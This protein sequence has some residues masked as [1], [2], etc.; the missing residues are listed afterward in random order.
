MARNWMAHK[1]CVTKSLCGT[2]SEF[3]RHLFLQ[4][5][6]QRTSLRIAFGQ[7]SHLFYFRLT[8]IIM[9]TLFLPIWLLLFLCVSKLAFILDDDQTKN[10]KKM[11]DEK[12]KKK[13]KERHYLTCNIN[14]DHHCRLNIKTMNDMR[15][16]VP[17]RNIHIKYIQTSTKCRNK[18]YWPIDCVSFSLDDRMES[19]N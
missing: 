11:D 8:H 4:T 13:I 7:F 16:I 19:L 3:I 9:V 18:T 5:Y 17:R 6:A 12:K 10:G 15:N 14:D 1:F 2:H